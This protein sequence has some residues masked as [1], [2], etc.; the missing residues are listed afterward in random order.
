MRWF[1][2]LMWAVLACTPKRVVAVQVKPDEPKLDI[3]APWVDPD[4][5]FPRGKPETKRSLAEALS[6]PGTPPVVIRGAR[7]MTALAR[8]VARNNSSAV[9]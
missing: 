9:K 3:V 5:F 7:V 4:A 6:D 1:L 8:N 2:P